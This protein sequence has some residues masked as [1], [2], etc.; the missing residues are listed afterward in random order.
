MC[1]PL[2]VV[3]PKSNKMNNMWLR[4][5]NAL[6]ALFHGFATVSHML[7]MVLPENFRSL[8]YVFRFCFKPTVRFYR[9]AIRDPRIFKY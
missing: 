2:V 4:N 5:L 3:L 7:A 1:W 8:L 6:D 9:A